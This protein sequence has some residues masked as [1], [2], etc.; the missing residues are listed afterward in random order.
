MSQYYANTGK[1]R[2]PTYKDGRTKQAFK[3]STDV[4][5]IIRKHVKR[6][7]IETLAKIEG[8]YGDFSDFDFLEAQNRVAAAKSLFEQLPAELRKEFGQDPG[9]FLAY[10][11]D[12]AN[13]ED[14]NRKLVDAV[15][16]GRQINVDRGA[17]AR[18]AMASVN[19]DGGTDVPPSVE[20]PVEG[21]T[22]G[23][24]A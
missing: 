3:D 11:N 23:T 17:G 15:D 22:G 18:G 19:E 4:N 12:P 10:A 9:A 1:L 6:G 20:E 7:T 16:P 13:A 24:P 21:D 14:L 2:F 5:K 8:Q